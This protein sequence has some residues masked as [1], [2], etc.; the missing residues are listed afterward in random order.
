MTTKDKPH[1]QLE[2]EYAPKQDEMGCDTNAN[3]G[4]MLL[5]KCC[6]PGVSYKEINKEVNQ[7]S[8]IDLHFEFMDGL[9]YSVSFSLLSALASST[10]LSMPRSFSAFCTPG[11]RVVPQTG[12]EWSYSDAGFVLREEWFAFVCFRCTTDVFWVL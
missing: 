7:S 12:R 9:R 5:N 10:I 3:S 8:K 1:G 4:A 6:D 2:V 11:Q